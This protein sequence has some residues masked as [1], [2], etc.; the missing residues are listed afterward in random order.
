MEM[1]EDII[2]GPIF[3]QV[4]FFA[5]QIAMSLFEIEMVSCLVLMNN[6]QIQNIFFSYTFFK[7]N[8]V[9]YI[10]S[11]SPCWR[12]SIFVNDQLFAMLFC[13]YFSNYCNIRFR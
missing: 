8:V 7:A 10:Q 12:Y 1:L 11:T 2:Q 5:L 3:Y 13:N 6:N 9:I 4:T